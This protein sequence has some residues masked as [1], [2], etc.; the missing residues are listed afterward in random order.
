MY[1]KK[2]VPRTPRVLGS[3]TYWAHTGHV[4]TGLSYVVSAQFLTQ[5]WHG[6]INLPLHYD[7]LHDSQPWAEQ[8]LLYRMKFS[9]LREFETTIFFSFGHRNSVIGMPDWHRFF[10]ALVSLSPEKSNLSPPTLAPRRHFFRICFHLFRYWCPR[11]RWNR[12][13]G[14]ESLNWNPPQPLSGG[15]KELNRPH[16]CFQLS[17]K[18]RI[19]SPVRWN[20][21]VRIPV[22]ITL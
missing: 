16:V 5:A 15:P 1:S 2:I 10:R 21:S 12:L 3:L 13:F 9:G 17:S 19:L 18:S 22:A 7:T 4:C 8:N 14:G 6:K 11:K 20:G